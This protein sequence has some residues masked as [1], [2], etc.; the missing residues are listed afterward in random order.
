MQA[1]E[2][3]GDDNGFVRGVKCR[4]LDMVETRKGLKLQVSDEEPVVLE[5]QCVIIANGHRPG[6]FLKQYLPQLKCDKDGALWVRCAR[7]A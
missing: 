5:A 7:P 4:K 1:L 2:I 6:D 3:M